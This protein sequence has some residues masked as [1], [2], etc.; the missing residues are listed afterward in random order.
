M[1]E[2][3][4][5][6]AAVARLPKAPWCVGFAAESQ[7]LLKHARDK[8]ERKRVALIVGNIGAATFGADDNEMVL[9]D[10]AGH[11]ALPRADKL[12][13][14]RTLIAEIADRLPFAPTCTPTP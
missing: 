10:A 5:I 7:D 9:V 11:R 14:A 13:L 8:L 12:S 6:L 3:P 1:T 2:N 4:D